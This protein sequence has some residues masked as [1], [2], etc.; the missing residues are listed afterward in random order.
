MSDTLLVSTRKG[1]FTVV[2]KGKGAWSIDRVSFLG[3]N[4]TLAMVDPRDGAWYATL[5]HG[6]FGVKLQRSEDRGA[7]WT[8]IGVPQYPEPP[9]GHEEKDWMGRAIPWKLIR[10]WALQAGGA[11]QPGLL[12]AGTLPGG[13]FWS[14]DRGAT[15]NLVRSLWD[16]PRRIQ[17]SGGG[18]DYAGLH[19]ICVDPRDSRH[20]LIAV[21][22]GGVWETK[23]RGVTW[24]LLG[25][26]LRAEYMPPEKAGDPLFQDVHHL[27]QCPG[28]PE[29]CWIQHHNG[30]FRSTDGART[31]T[32]LKDVPPSVFGFAVAVH[33]KDPLTAW[34]VPGIKDEKR[35]PVGGQVV[36]TRTRDGA[37]TF[38]VLRH[39][40]PQE[41]AYDLVLRH[42]L[43]ID[44]TGDRLAFGSSTGSLWVTEDGGDH[45][46][47]VS[48]HLPPVYAVCFVK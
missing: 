47:T 32:E 13:L 21:S 42:A 29:H 27:V 39:G 30:M 4:V 3:D 31:W 40:L 16:D 9:E 2:R 33:P 38:E 23:D 26:G 24:E 44:A 18:A 28:A 10:I 17:W 43:D 34:F 41:H 35:I 20:L 14:D 22:T 8:E 6:H 19:S 1:L 11:D 25:Q 45:W 12:W 37:K 7:T 36:V 15:W 48:E 5:D 46:G